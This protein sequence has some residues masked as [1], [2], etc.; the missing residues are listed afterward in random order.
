VQRA[1]LEIA[2]VTGPQGPH[3]SDSVPS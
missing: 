3:D 1:L 2:G